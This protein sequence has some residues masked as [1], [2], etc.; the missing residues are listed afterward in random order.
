[1]T[2]IDAAVDPFLI[3]VA[4]LLIG[5]GMMMI[6]R[7][8]GP[9]KLVL[10]F[11]AQSFMNVY[12]SWLMRKSVVIPA[13]TTI[14]STQE[15][16]ENDL[17]GLPAGFALTALQQ[18]ISFAVFL[19]L[20]G[21]AYFTPYRYVPKA[22]NSKFEVFCVIIF[23]FVFCMNIALN[24]FSLSLISIA[25]NLIIRSCLPLTTFL[26]QQG[27]SMCN[28][29]PRKPFRVLEITL[30]CIGVCCA[31]VFTWASLQAKGVESKG[32]DSTMLLL[33]G[34]LV[35]IASL[36]CGSLNLALAGVLGTSV[37]LNP[38]DTVAYMA[39]P[40]TLFLLP[41]IFFLQKPVPGEWHKVFGKDTATDGE[42]FMGLVRLC[43]EHD[44]AMK[45]MAFGI[46]S[47]V[48]S[49]VYNIIQFTIVHTLSPSATAFGGN[50]NK[51][52]LIFLSYIFMDP[53]PKAP[54]GIVIMFAIIG[55]IAAFSYYSYLQFKAK[56]ED[57]K[58]KEAK[59]AKEKGKIMV[60]EGEDESEDDD[61]D[62]DSS[63]DGNGRFC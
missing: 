62:E 20:F 45:T 14:E 58:A 46:L 27:L 22:L 47:G 33:L 10:Y 56:E 37:H 26:S 41:F 43:G 7:V 3:P 63:S 18:V 19:I 13:G 40:A 34:V 1:M 25:V 60:E 51:A 15:T 49:F 61:S 16:V 12:M 55:N 39:V 2:I 48:F 59:E 53:L 30:M 28:L 29:F 50:F 35:C 32:K 6:E 17:T 31:G 44:G 54:W 8:K 52:A 11:G 36:L 42:I 24:N 5:T 38:L 21:V 9:G 4:G 57:K 23:G